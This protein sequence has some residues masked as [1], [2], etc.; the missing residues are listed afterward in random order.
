MIRVIMFEDEPKLI[1]S[2]KT[3]WEDSD[4]IFLAAA[5]PNAKEAVAEVKRHKPDVVLMD[6]QMP[7]VWGIEAMANIKKALPDTLVLM[8]TSFP[9]DDK[10]FAAIC[11]G[12]SGYVLKG[13]MAE[14]EQAIKEVYAGGG[15]FT[16]SIAMRVMKMFQAQFVV[17]QP[18]YARLT[19]REKDVLAAMVKGMSYKM[20]A[21]ALDIKYDTVHDHV[22]NIYKK[23]HVNSASEAVREA[24]LKKLV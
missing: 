17:A 6:I 19:P 8:L 9:D 24:I 22:K 7:G 4:D 20:V 21:D 15:H 11:G 12:A 23:L 18:T 5:F 14:V 1:D 13:N 10:I 16:P 2:L 3:Y